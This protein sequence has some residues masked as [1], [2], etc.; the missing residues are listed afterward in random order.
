ML[1]VNSGYDADWIRVA[2]QAEGIQP[3]ILGRRS[4]NKPL[5]HDKRR[6]WRRSQIEIIFGRL[7]NWRPAATRYDR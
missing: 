5:K 4:R 6:Y 2:L 7:R 3:C 1:S